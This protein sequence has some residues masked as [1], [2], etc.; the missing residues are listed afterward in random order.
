MRRI[1]NL[2][3][4]PLFILGVG[5]LF[6]GSLISSALTNASMVVLLKQS[7]CDQVERICYPSKL[8]E[9][10]KTRIARAQQWLEA[11]QKWQP[12]SNTIRLH[13]VEVLYGLGF[14]NDAAKLSLPL[15]TYPAGRSFL[16]PI[17]LLQDYK[18]YLLTAQQMSMAGNWPEA[19]KDFRMGLAWGGETDPA[20]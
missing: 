14:R 10:D 9:G 6:R 1:F 2:A 4:L 7:S 20:R 19:V 13:L 18:Y 11:A 8:P 12:N 15:D 16:V 3:W 5:F 17:G